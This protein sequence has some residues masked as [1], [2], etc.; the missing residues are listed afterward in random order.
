MLTNIV[1]AIVLV[2]MTCT[3]AGANVT[4]KTEIVNVGAKTKTVVTTTIDGEYIEE[5]EYNTLT[6]D[7]EEK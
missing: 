1:A 6:N 2:A 5:Y 3:G 4:E 7:W